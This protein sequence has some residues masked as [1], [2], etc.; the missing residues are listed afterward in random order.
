MG[1]GA[2]AR[3]RW[4]RSQAASGSQSSPLLG[5]QTQLSCQEATL[6]RTKGNRGPSAAGGERYGPEVLPWGLAKALGTTLQGKVTHWLATVSPEGASHTRDLEPCPKGA[7][8]YSTH[9]QALGST[10]P[11]LKGHWWP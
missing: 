7:L 2:D 10:G 8:A 6:E 4:G 9:S 3:G 1:G 5:A 11:L